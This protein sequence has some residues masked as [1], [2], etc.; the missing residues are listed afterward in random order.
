MPYSE[1][2]QLSLNNSAPN[3]SLAAYPVAIVATLPQGPLAQRGWSILP[4]ILLPH[5][6]GF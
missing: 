4:Y 5:G 1:I 2:L 6:N 3:H